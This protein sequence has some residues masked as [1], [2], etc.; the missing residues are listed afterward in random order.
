MKKIVIVF[1]IVAV[2]VVSGW[3]VMHLTNPSFSTVQAF[4]EGETIPIESSFRAR[5]ALV[6]IDRLMLAS[7]HWAWLLGE[8]EVDVREAAEAL[9]ISP[10]RLRMIRAIQAVDP[11][12]SETLGATDDEALRIAWQTTRPFETKLEQLHTERQTL[13]DAM[14]EAPDESLRALVEAFLEVDAELQAFREAHQAARELTEPLRQ[15][16]RHRR[17]NRAS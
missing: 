13:V 14:R 15:A 16:I 11:D 5:R 10:A 12:F 6:R 9:E 17:F 1:A 8:E 3:F 7:G 2:L 4:T